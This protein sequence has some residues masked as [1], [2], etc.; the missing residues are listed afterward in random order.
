MQFKNYVIKTTVLCFFVIFTAAFSCEPAFESGIFLHILP[1][2]PHFLIKTRLKSQKANSDQQTKCTASIRWSKYTTQT[3]WFSYNFS[4]KI[5]PSP[6]LVANIILKVLKTCKQ[7]KSSFKNG[8][9][10]KDIPVIWSQDFPV[11][12]S[13]RNSHKMCFIGD[14]LYINQV[15]LYRCLWIIDLIRHAAGSAVT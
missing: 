10:W 8:H 7:I 3:I 15:P 12:K 11:L 2:F 5:T 4:F 1:H 14:G 6:K 13:P 9:W